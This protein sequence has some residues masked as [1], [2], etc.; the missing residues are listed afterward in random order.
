M[1]RRWFC[2]SVVEFRC[3][4]NKVEHGCLVVILPNDGIGATDGRWARHDFRVLERFEVTGIERDTVCSSGTILRVDDGVTVAEGR[5]TSGNCQKSKGEDEGHQ[6][7]H[8]ESNTDE[9]T[10]T[11]IRTFPL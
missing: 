7:R 11:S 6:S 2:P 10:N 4:G 8:E 3:L 1:L 9:K 5:D